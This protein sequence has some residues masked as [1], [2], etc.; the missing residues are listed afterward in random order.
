MTI[1]TYIGW[2]IGG[3]NTKISIIKSNR[4]NSE[5]HEIEL[6]HDDGLSKLKKLV[7][8]FGINQSDTYH[9][10]TLSGEMCDIFP[11]R[12]NGINTILSFFKKFSSKERYRTF[13]LIMLRHDMYHFD[14]YQTLKQVF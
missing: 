3:S 6:W 2:D 9:G 8:D 4:A 14:S 12:E 1:K 11:S 13:L 7:S 10:I 5:V